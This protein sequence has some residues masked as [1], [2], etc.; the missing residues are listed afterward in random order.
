MG[1]L[2]RG[3]NITADG[4]AR[5]LVK[6]DATFARISA[7]LAD[8]RRYL[9]GDRFTVADLTFAALAAPVL[10]PDDV[11]LGLPPREFFGAANAQIDAW[12]A[13][14]AGAFALRIY[15]EDR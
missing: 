2:R 15:K 8:G 12:R 4:V 11:D 3:L 6:I 1:M 9:V 5:S 10:Q 13:T 14:P 7:L